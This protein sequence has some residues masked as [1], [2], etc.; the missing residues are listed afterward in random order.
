M[1]KI[2]LISGIAL[3]IIGIASV[4]YANPS[5]L[6]SKASSSTASST[7]TYMTPGTATTTVIYDSYGQGGTNQT[8]AYNSSKT[9]EAF[10]A[11]Q[12]TASSTSTTLNVDLEFANGSNCYAA[13]NTCDWYRNNLEALSTTTSPALLNQNQTMTWTFASSTQGQIG[14]PTKINRVNKM[15]TIPT[16][17]RYTRAIFTLP[18]GS[19][20]G[21]VYAEIQP[22]K[23]VNN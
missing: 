22:V 20:N 23:E 17:T 11:I 10:L 13:P 1:K 14:D 15:V 2:Y 3:G 5:F 21:A 9:D 7:V 12:L 19:A 18:A 4:A 8:S 16:P 6:G